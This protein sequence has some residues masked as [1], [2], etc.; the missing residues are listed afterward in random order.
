MKNVICHIAPTL[1]RGRK[2]EGIKVLY[3]KACPKCHGDVELVVYP[4]SKTLQCLQC[5]FTVDS[6]EAARRALDEKKTAAKTEAA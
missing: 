5:A 1:W 4:D 6:K 3:L 2:V